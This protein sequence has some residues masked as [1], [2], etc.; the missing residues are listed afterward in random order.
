MSTHVRVSERTRD[1]L[2][3]LQDQWALD[4]V[5]SV[6]AFIL[7]NVDIADLT[8]QRNR[9]MLLQLTEDDNDEIG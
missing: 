1:I 3:A 5:E 4:S 9:A 7:F 6:L 2:R 8:A